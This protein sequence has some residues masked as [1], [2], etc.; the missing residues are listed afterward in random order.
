MFKGVGSV[1]NTVLNAGKTVVNDVYGGAKHLVGDVHDLAEGI[2]KKGGGFV[3]TFGDLFKNIAS[4]G[5]YLLLGA[6]AIFLVIE[7]KGNG[8]KDRY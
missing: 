1:G 4:F 3:D 5:P 6:G 7:L 8:E 2:V